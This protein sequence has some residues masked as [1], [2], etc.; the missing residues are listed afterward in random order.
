MSNF[1]LSSSRPGL[2][3]HSKLMLTICVNVCRRDKIF[4]ISSSSLIMAWN[5]FSKIF[6]QNAEYVP[7]M[8]KSVRI[9]GLMEK[10]KCDKGKV[11]FSAFYRACTL[12]VSELSIFHSAIEGCHLWWSPFTS[13]ITMLLCSTKHWQLN[14]CLKYYSC[15]FEFSPNFSLVRRAEE[16][17]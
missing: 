6:Y 5:Q 8:A 3:P 14:C 11:V 12:L 17:N 15:C 13:K 1:K 9:G 2:V 4:L 7:P 10:W 16:W